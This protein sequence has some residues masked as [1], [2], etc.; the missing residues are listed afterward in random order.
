VVG[1]VETVL[2]MRGWFGCLKEAV[3][4]LWKPL[5]GKGAKEE[6]MVLD[7]K[8]GVNTG[9][10]G[11]LGAR[12]ELGL[13]TLRVAEGGTNCGPRGA[14]LLRDLGIYGTGHGPVR[15]RGVD[16]ELGFCGAGA[17][18]AD[19]GVRPTQAGVIG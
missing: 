17:P 5:E 10:I 12:G 13:P 9:L 16:R 2:V 6:K 19:Q 3:A 11:I 14:G 15:T 1:S 4:Q 7:S 8:R 18:R